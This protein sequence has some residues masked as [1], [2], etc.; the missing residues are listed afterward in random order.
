MGRTLPSADHT[1]RRRARV[2]AREPDIAATDFDVG[3]LVGV[4]ASAGHFGGDAKQPHVT[5]RMHTDHAALFAWLVR[6][7]GGKLYGPYRH[8]GRMYY[9]WMARGAHLREVLV[10]LFER[11]L[12]P[13]LD[14]K[15]WDR[16]QVM[17][18]RYRIVT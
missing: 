15:A 13:D 17:K 18:R 4:L 9:Q 16:F 3:F 14:L 8:G 2:P 11:H 1:W 12:T 10:P 7:F 5:L 6:R